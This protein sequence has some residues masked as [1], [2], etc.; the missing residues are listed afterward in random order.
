MSV[1]P[2]Q[3]DL[4]RSRGD[5]FPMQ[6]TVKREDGTVVDVTGIDFLMTVDPDPDPIVSGNNLFQ[7][8]GVVTNGPAGIVRFTPSNAQMDQDPDTYFYDIQ[9]TDTG[10]TIRTVSAGK[11]KIVQDITKNL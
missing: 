5:T 9:M 3:L 4:C 8:V 2:Q 10:G 7:L 1:T 6:F 11:F